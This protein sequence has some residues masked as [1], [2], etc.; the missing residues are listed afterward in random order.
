MKSFLHEVTQRL[1][2][3][4]GHDLSSVTVVFNNRRS[5]LFFKKQLLKLGGSSFFMP[6][7]M[8][9]DDLICE[10]SG[11]E[12]VKREYLLYELYN[13]H[14]QISGENRKY[15]TFDEFVSFGE[16]MLSDFSEID[17]YQI[18]AKKLFGNLHDL[19]A[20]GEWNIE[21]NPLTPFQE[22]YLQFYKSLYRYYE[23]FRNRLR[24]QGKAYGGMAYRIIAEQIAQGITPPISGK[25]FFVGFNALSASELVIIQSLCHQGLAELISDGDAYYFDDPYQEAGYFL[26]EH[27]KKFKTIGPFDNHFEQQEKNIHL[28]DCPENLLQVK[29]AGEILRQMVSPN[30]NPSANNE[31][32][33]SQQETSENE[34]SE[35]LQNTAVVLADESLLLPMLHSIPSQIRTFNVTMGYPFKLSA[36]HTMMLRLFSL[37]EHARNDQ[38]Y[39]KDLV[40]VLSDTILS[41]LIGA[42]DLRSSLQTLFLKHKQPY[43]NYPSLF[44]LLKASHID[45]SPLSYWLSCSQITP[46]QF[47]E[48]WKQ[49]CTTLLSQKINDPKEKEALLTLNQLADYFIDL[50]QRYHFVQQLDTLKRIYIR[51]AQRLSISF[52]SEPLSGLQLLGVLETR[53]LDFKRIIL[54]GANEGILP[55]DHTANTLIPYS[56]KHLFHL[57]THIEKDA[58]YANHFYRLLQ[59]AEEVFILYSSQTNT[60]SKGEPSRFVMQLKSELIPRYPNIHL[61]EVLL[62]TP[63]H[64]PP[65]QPTDSFEK[66]EWVLH[67][68]DEIAE[69]G[70][71][72]SALNT[73][74]S[75]PKR[76][77][78]ENVLSIREQDQLEEDIDSSEFGT[79]VHKVL[80][81]IYRNHID[82]KPP[83]SIEALKNYRS[84]IDNLI[85]RIFTENLGGLSQ[86]GW[87]YVQKEMA[88]SQ[89]V[90]MLNHDIKE[91]ESGGTIVIKGLEKELNST[92]TIQIGNQK[93]QVHIKGFIDRIEYH[94]GTLRIIDYKTG[95]VPESDLKLKNALLTSDNISDKLLQV[96]FYAWGYDGDKNDLTAGIYPLR[97]S[98]FNY[99]PAQIDT[100][101]DFII[102]QKSLEA[103]ESVIKEL[104]GNIMNLEIPF[105][106]NHDSVACPHCPFATACQMAKL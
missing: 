24:S 96:L 26:R 47:L 66:N 28:I 58:V 63:N 27:A 85:D 86:Q 29:Y 32:Q 4:Y 53:N 64:T 101:A 6:R 62:S 39:H 16:V 95:K 50:Q 74:R 78:Y 12:I 90:N 88:K 73:F 48:N 14:C 57:P 23:A 19:K 42:S 103:F 43:F 81:T 7:Y 3:E 1:F 91:L 59:R 94:N 82:N 46:D 31:T 105:Q 102:N 30:P 55:A 33:P 89:V 44:E 75:C 25:I 67:R 45:I 99:L 77:Y 106:A 36:M 9:I 84:D 38:F 2:Q 92:L 8:G 80:E 104:I 52:W 79:L 49:L 100:N 13:V 98:S 35:Q 71:S 18:D 76:Y 61:D 5:G 69:K 15:E 34:L 68:L 20:I 11:L 37:F 70:F 87:N 72:A 40:E 83:L 41:K 21:G 93:K 51:L 60:S 54:I 17:L 10:W 56:L 22:Q 65:P 97:S